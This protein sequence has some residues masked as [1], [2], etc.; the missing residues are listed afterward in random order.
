[1]FCIP[2]KFESNRRHTF[3]ENPANIYPFR[4]ISLFIEIYPVNPSFF[5]VQVIPLLVDTYIPLIVLEPAIIFEPTATICETG[6][7]L[8]LVVGVNVYPLSV[9]FKTP[10][11]EVPAYTST[12]FVAIQLAE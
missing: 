10:P 8:K 11:L 1:M 4:Y 6:L 3:V 12:P 7:L 2:T 5:C 9:D